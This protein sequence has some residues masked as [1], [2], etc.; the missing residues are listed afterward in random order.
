VGR[1]RCGKKA[2]RQSTTV[3]TERGTTGEKKKIVR[4]ETDIAFGT[5]EMWRGG[6]TVTT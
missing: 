4:E 6:A 3:K 2:F 5:N 1:S